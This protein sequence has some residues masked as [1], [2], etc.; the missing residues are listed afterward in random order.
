MTSIIG[1]R[2]CRVP[3]K[4]KGK[5][6]SNSPFIPKHNAQ[7]KQ[8]ARVLSAD[9]DREAICPSYPTG[10]PQ[11]QEEERAGW[12]GGEKTRTPTSKWGAAGGGSEKMER[13]VI[14]ICAY[15]ISP[16]RSTRWTFY[17]RLQNG[18][19][20]NLLLDINVPF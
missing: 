13:R 11:Q 8:H 6:S 15:I 2:T 14:F 19:I 4:P 10:H 17:T 18:V 1:I 20:Y 16:G 5:Q 3:R 7:S 12:P 9:P